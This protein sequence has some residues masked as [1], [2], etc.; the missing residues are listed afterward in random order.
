MAESGIWREAYDNDPAVIYEL[1]EDL[2]FVRCNAAWDR[3]AR[4]NGAHKSIGAR[5]LGRCIMD[6]TP[7]ALRNFYRTAYDSVRSF[8]RQWWHIYACS[9]PDLSR[10][11]QMRILPAGTDGILVVNTLIREEP[12]DERV[13]ARVEQY[14]D[15]EGT[16]TM[17]AHCRRAEHLSQPGRWDWVP[18]L[19]L[20]SG[21]LVK[22]GLCQFCFAYHYPPRP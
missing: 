12:H 2:R 15:A 10:S 11:I 17:C 20:S 8:Q 14:T 9:S 6:F 18:S 16:A 5:V 4:E 22:P 21:T 3:F 1:D 19:L 7:H 13:R